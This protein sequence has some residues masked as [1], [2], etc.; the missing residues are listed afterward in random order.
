MSL[1]YANLE[2]EQEEVVSEFFLGEDV[3]VSLPTKF[4]T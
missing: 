4:G 3:F 1:G 2:P